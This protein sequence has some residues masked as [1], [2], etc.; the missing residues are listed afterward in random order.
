MALA[1]RTPWLSVEDYLVGEQ[2]STLRHELID[3]EAYL[4]AG[5][6]ANHNT[7]M[8]NTSTSIVSYL[9]SIGSSCRT[10][11]A[12]MKVNSG[13]NFYYPD[14]V[15]SCQDDEEEDDY[16]RTKPI[17]IIEVLSPS[18]RQTD[19]TIKKQDYLA[20]PSLEEYVLLEQDFVEVEVFSKSDDWHPRYYYLDDTICLD[21]IGLTVSVADLYRRVKNRDMEEY[22]AREQESA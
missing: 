21:S 17:L 20:I 15:V 12:D 9:N 1:Q 16:Y 6:S 18:T 5:A 8:V 22:M 7:L 4:M 11:S 19:R 10:F 3:G 14:V 13:E 2:E